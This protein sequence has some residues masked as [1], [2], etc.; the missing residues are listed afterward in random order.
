VAVAKAQ[1]PELIKVLRQE[2]SDVQLYKILKR[3]KN[4]RAY[5]RNKSFKDT[6]DRMMAH[7]SLKSLRH[8]E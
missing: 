2:L 4:T 8:Y 5:D 3:M 1:L 6:I 7:E